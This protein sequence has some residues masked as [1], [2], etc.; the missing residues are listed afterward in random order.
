MKILG[1]EVFRRAEI[2]KPETPV[3]ETKSATQPT[4]VQAVGTWQNILGMIRESFSGSWQQSVVVDNNPRTLLAFSAVYSCITGIA[5][6][7]AKMYIKLDQVA[8]DGV[9]DC[10][11]YLHGNDKFNWVLKL[12]RK[13]NHFQNRI[14]FITAWVLS[15]LMY[16]NA[17]I[18]KER[19]ITNPNEI[20]AMYVLSPLYIVPL[21]ATDGS[22][23]YGLNM[24]WLSQISEGKTVPASEIIHDRMPELW[25][26]LIGVSPLYA[27]AMSVM[28]GNKIQANSTNFFANSSRPGGILTAPGEISDE[29][30]ARLKAAWETNYSGANAGRIAVLGDNLKFEAM[31]EA[32]EQSQLIEQ[33]K[34]TVSDC[35]R[36]F[37]YPEFKLGGTIPSGTTVESL[38]ILYYTDC[39]QNLV[40]SLEACLDDGLGLPVDMG[41]EFD[42]DCLLRMDTAA[43]YESNDKGVGGG[44]L[45]P[46]EARKRDNR[47]GVPGGKMP[48]LQQQNY[49]LEALAKR[50]AKE[51]PFKTSNPPPK[52]VDPNAN[53]DALPAPPVPPKPEKSISLEDAL[54]MSHMEI[55][56]MEF[57]HAA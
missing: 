51:D 18:L 49:S 29:T 53:P 54:M 3:T 5:S 16:G 26:P 9:W 23:F 31:R 44:W 35:A 52:P 6:D 43:L 22:V 42:V 21:V 45:A 39:L 20:V 15:K 12:L 24:D 37:H 19:S 55:G 2:N 4:V 1:I 7:V 40:E 10:I 46:D 27:C 41:T 36:A 34:W 11:D 48:Y 8:E 17:Y 25:H 38:N 50:D 56:R 30:A 32:A 47:H 33:L 28:M 14:Q 13:P 57:K